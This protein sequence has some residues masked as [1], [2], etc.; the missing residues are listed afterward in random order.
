MGMGQ[1]IRTGLG[2]RGGGASRVS[3]RHNFLVVKAFPRKVQL[4]RALSRGG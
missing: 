4:Y 3:Y 2:H 1:G